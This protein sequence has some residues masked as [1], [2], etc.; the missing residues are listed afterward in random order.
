M[1]QL[2]MR[3]FKCVFTAESQRPQRFN[4]FLLSDKRSVSKNEQSCWI[5]KFTIT[6]ILPEHQKITF[7]TEL[8]SRFLLPSFSTAKGK[9]F[10]FAF[11]A[12]QAMRPVKK[13]SVT[14]TESFLIPQNKLNGHRGCSSTLPW[15]LPLQQRRFQV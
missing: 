1:F 8:L 4:I 7:A 11:L 10:I 12:S 9:R 15:F 14:N 2:A 5:K 6:T 3:I 13:S